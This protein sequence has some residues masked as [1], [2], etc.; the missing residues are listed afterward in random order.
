MD[1]NQEACDAECVAL[2]RALESA[3]RRQTTPERGTIFT[4][5]RAAIRRM[6]SRSLAPAKIRALG[7]EAH[8]KARPD[9]TIEIR[10]CPARK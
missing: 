10:W 6:V 2:A 3:S 9:T 8:W 5:A 4:D 1:Y 7:E